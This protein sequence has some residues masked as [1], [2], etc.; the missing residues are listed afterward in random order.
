[1]G[2]TAYSRNPATSKG[3]K[4]LTQSPKLQEKT[5][6]SIIKIPTKLLKP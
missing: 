4:R 1:M 2:K 6:E 5:S 3:T